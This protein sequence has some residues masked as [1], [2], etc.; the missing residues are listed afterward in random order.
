MAGRKTGDNVQFAIVSA[1]GT[2]ATAGALPLADGDGIEPIADE[3]GQ[4]WV[5]VSQSITPPG[6]PTREQAS[7]AALTD[8]EV[9]H[10]GA[11]VLSVINGLNNDGAVL[12]YAQVYDLAAAPGPGDVPIQVIPVAPMA[13][14]SWSPDLWEFTNGIVVAMSTVPMSFASAGAVMFWQANFYTP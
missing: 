8:A 7:A 3:N 14:W 5:R 11:A 2:R 6:Y 10:N 12:H 4:L 9:V 13:E 1:D